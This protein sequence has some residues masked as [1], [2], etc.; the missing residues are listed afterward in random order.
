MRLTAIFQGRLGMNVNKTRIM[1]ASL[2]IMIIFES[3]F[4]SQL[5]EILARKGPTL[6]EGFASFGDL[7]CPPEKPRPP[8]HYRTYVNLLR[9]NNCTILAV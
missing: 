1:I 6:Q 2:S 8:C 9:A 3:A 7:N 5:N 4:A